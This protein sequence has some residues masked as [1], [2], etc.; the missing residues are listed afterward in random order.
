METKM[1]KVITKSILVAGLIGMSTSAL[2]I[3]AEDI[4]NRME[5]RGYTDIETSTTLFGNTLIV[6][7]IDGSKHEFVINKSGVVL[8]EHSQCSVPVAASSRSGG[9]AWLPAQSETRLTWSRPGLA[10][11]MYHYS[12][13]FEDHMLSRLHLCL[14][15][16]QH[17]RTHCVYACV[18]V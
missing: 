8:R 3:D 6:G 15:S 10:Q 5:T 9:A 18:K 13:L 12:A 11:C 7:I 1:K 14:T 16:L 2:A 4:I 17:N